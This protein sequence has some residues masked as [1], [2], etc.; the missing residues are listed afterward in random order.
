MA[1]SDAEQ[2]AAEPAAVEPP[3][4]VSKSGQAPRVKPLP[5]PDR[6]AFD[7]ELAKLQAAT[8]KA[9]ARLA[10][11][12]AEIK[13]K[14]ASRKASAGDSSTAASRA[15]LA[16]LNAVFKARMVRPFARHACARG[17]GRG[18]S[19]RG[20]LGRSAYV[21]S[22]PAL[23]DEKAA[24]REELTA[25]D[26]ARDRA[27]EELKSA[28]GALR[29][30][31]P[32]EITQEVARLQHMLEHTTMP[33]NDEKK[34][35]TQIKEL[36]KSRDDVKAF[37]ERSAKLV[38]SED[39]RKELVER[40]RA[41]DAEI[42]AA[43]A[44]KAAV[45]ATLSAARAKEESHVAGLP[46]LHEERDKVWQAVR[47]CRDAVRKLRDEHKAEEDVWW[48]NEKLWRSQQKEEKQKRCAWPGT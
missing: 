27:R 6:A 16:E 32:E 37:G 45:Q 43:K 33:L 15:R 35:L 5:K 25:M 13:E 3:A 11:L 23:Q 34:L 41:K 24:L 40:I 1:T 42:T 2:P 4:E 38:G 39:A 14:N 8:E 21:L 7:A 29:F 17:C 31:S 44:D 26:A 47:A 36:T 46:A 9:T 18:R 28:R 20:R 19:R 48:A 10:V 22:R 12:D 30:R